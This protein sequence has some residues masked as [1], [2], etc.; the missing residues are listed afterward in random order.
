MYDKEFKSQIPIFIYIELSCLKILIIL[1]TL[2]F[3]ELFFASFSMPPRIY[4]CASDGER[5]SM[6]TCTSV[7]ELASVK[8]SLS[9]RVMCE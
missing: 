2:K 8:E 5:A 7:W 4:I 1:K 3:P 9:V 6:S